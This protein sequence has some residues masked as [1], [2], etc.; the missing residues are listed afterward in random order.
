MS[1]GVWSRHSF[2]I[3]SVYGVMAPLHVE[4][5]FGLIFTYNLGGFY[6]QFRGPI[7]GLSLLQDLGGYVS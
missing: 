7:S 6:I 4:F 2:I 3:L 1:G 5:I